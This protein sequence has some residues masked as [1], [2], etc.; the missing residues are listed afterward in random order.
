MPNSHA[1]APRQ[2]RAFHALPLATLILLAILFGTPV[3]DDRQVARAQSPAAPVH[4]LAAQPENRTRIDEPFPAPEE[5]RGL[6]LSRQTPEAAAAKSA[7]C[8][9]C[10]QGQ[11]DP[12]S[13]PETV[14]LG[15]VD[16]HGG[17]PQAANQEAAHVWP[18]FP[19]AWRSSA[20]PVRSYTLLNHENPDFIRFVNPGDLRI[21][22][23]SCGTTSCHADQ[24]LQVRKSM[25][26]H[27][28]MLWGS[29]LFNNGS[30]PFKRARYGQSYSMNGAPQRLQTVPPPTRFEMEHK[31]VVP[32]LDPLP[33]FEASQPGNVLRIFERGRREPQEIGIPNPFEDP[34]KPRAGL[35]ARGLGTKNRTDPVFVGL[36]KTRLFDPTLNFLGTNDHPGDYRS[37][38]CTACHVIYANDRSIVNSGPYAGFGNQ[39]LSAQGDPTIP[40]DEPGHPIKHQ[41]AVGIPTSQCIVCHVHPGTN[42]LNSYTGYMWWDEE[43]DGE[44]LYPKAQ[45]YPTAEE[46]TLANMSNPDET[47]ARGNWSDPAFLARVA[48]LNPQARHTQF[49]D[50]HG[51]GWVFRA[52]YKKDRHG[53][54]LDHRGEPAASDSTAALMA[55][56]ALPGELKERY[57]TRDAAAAQR[58]SFDRAGSKRDG[59]PVHQ[60]DIHLEKGMHCVDCH[61]IQ[62]AHGNTKL[63]GEVRA[64]IE[65][66]CV[67]CHGSPGERATLFTS[68]PASDTSAAETGKEGRDLSVLRTPFQARR[69]ERR[70]EKII[71]RS[72][73]EP[74][75][76]WEITQVAETID[77]RSEHYNQRAHLAKTVRF[78]NEQMV[79]GDL[80]SDGEKA[81]AHASAKMSCIACHSAWNPSCFGCHLPQRANRKMPQLHN[82]GD[83]TRNY[84]SYNFQTLRDDVFMLARD[85]N[86][87]ANRIGPARSSC[88]IHVGSYNANR[89]SIYVQQQTISGDGLSGIAFSTNV[90]H[91]VRGGP[92]VV[93]D[94][95]QP[96]NPQNGRP[97]N[98]GAYLPGHSDTKACTDCHL[99]KAD[100]NNAIMAQ[101]LMQGTNYVNFIGRY[102]W[103]AAGDHG[104]AAVVVTER[105]EPQAVIG[106]SL[107]Q[108]AYPDNYRKHLEAA[109]KL[110]HSHEHSGRDVGE[111][112]RRPEV[113]SIQARGEYLYAACGESGL[114]VF[115]IAFIDHKGFSERIVTAPV[116]PLGQRFFVRTSYA[117]AV[118]APTTMAPDPTRQHQPDNH[119]QIVHAMY[120]YI[121]VTDRDEGLILVP[122]GTLLDGNPLNNFLGRELTFNPDNILHGARAITIVGTFAYISCDAGIVVVSLDQPKHPAV[123]SLVGKP[124]LNHPRAFQAQFRY[125]YACDEEGI[126][127]LDITDL[128]HPQPVGVLPLRD[129]RGIYLARTYAYV[130]GGA[131]GLVILDIERP[132]EPRIDQVYAAGG[133]INDLNDVKL[134]I[135]YVSEFAYL[136]DGKNGLRVVQLTSPE[137]PGNAGFSPRPT[138]RLI[139]SFKLPVGANARAISEGVDRDRAVDESGNQIGVFG[140]V[141]ARP[142]NGEEQRRMY[143]HNN[144]IWKVS[145]DP[146][147]AV[148]RRDQ[149]PAR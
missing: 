57:R 128:A 92:P 141:G 29:A 27:G 120:G 19:E 13:K 64:A 58:A 131:L 100:D 148:Y 84:V 127:V 38:G 149:K 26:T 125:A 118:A 56:V 30:V 69:F 80:P 114:R 147:D 3:R 82:E 133:I 96:Q 88:A 60:L 18:R 40:R 53:N 119:E 137:T 12:H 106:S 10:H 50:F 36:Q 112:I 117:T 41:F 35:S 138:P 22:H 14:R 45:K 59:L 76:A 33:R 28:S 143:I 99:S 95:A 85:G 91:T 86:A 121:Y 107:H 134:G 70:G 81:C 25:M 62:D 68:G 20:N 142:L 145:D 110:K 61:F 132:A 43:T 67:D 139:A 16:C 83:I 34:G 1:G 89:E 103:V 126:K 93:H 8:I 54:L 9:T 146:L 73:V 17:N 71:Q 105:D 31:G 101:L 136:A 23:L 113:L 2:L 66:Q 37:S 116:S 78:E 115:D 52:V 39:G 104:L 6:D 55:A 75:L 108:L 48:E 47:A 109:G 90:P 11:H 79:W 24:V 123:T 49:A 97:P 63:Y 21:A 130:A 74:D 7:G 44:L 98:P 46:F 111:R 102:C 140:R 15:C 87:T 124:F 5:I 32:F 144:Q 65:I 122:A 129:A 4:A 72:M 77:P 51:H 135:T 42:V 94:P